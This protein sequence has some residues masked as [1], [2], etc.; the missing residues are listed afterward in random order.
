[1]FKLLFIEAELMKISFHTHIDEKLNFKFYNENLNFNI[2]TFLCL[3]LFQMDTL[4]ASV[5][6]GL[7]HYA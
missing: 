6:D 7:F 5:E 3:S 4:M 1:M 2:K